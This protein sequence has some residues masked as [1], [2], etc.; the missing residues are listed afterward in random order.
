MIGRQQDYEKDIQGRYE[1]VDLILLDLEPTALSAHS[2]TSLKQVVEIFDRLQLNSLMINE[3]GNTTKLSG[4]VD[5]FILARLVHNKFVSLQHEH[6]S[7]YLN[8]YGE[9]ETEFFHHRRDRESIE[10]IS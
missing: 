10:L 2:K 9:E 1:G 6:E 8:G 3:Y 5:R 4:F 7:E